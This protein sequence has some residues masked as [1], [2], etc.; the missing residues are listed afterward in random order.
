MHW[1]GRVLKAPPA[2]VLLTSW[3][4]PLRRSRVTAATAFCAAA[5]AAAAAAARGL[6]Q[7]R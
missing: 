2:A 5:A 6:L 3:A 1:E 4:Q 7:R